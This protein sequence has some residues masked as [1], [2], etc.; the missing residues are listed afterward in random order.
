MLKKFNE[1]KKGLNFIEVSQKVLPKVRT[2][3]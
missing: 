1:I 2:K 3:I